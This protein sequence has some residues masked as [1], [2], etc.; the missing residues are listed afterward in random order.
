MYNEILISHK[1]RW[2]IAIYDNMA[3]S[4][5]YHAK[6][7]KSDGKKSDDFTHIWDKKLKTTN[8]YTGHTYK[9]NW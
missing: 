7:N 1:N 6:G 2:N 8:K 9:Q 5:A 4:W 3:R